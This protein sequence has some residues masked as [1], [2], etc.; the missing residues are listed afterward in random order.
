MFVI[1]SVLSGVDYGA[2]LAF[3][4][5]FAGLRWL[6]FLFV[7]MVVPF[8]LF[9]LATLVV[10][11]LG[12]PGD[13]SL[14]GLFVLFVFFGVG[15]EDD[16]DKVSWIG[17]SSF[18]Q[19]LSLLRPPINL[20]IDTT[21]YFGVAAPTPAQMDILR[22]HLIGIPPF[23]EV[24]N[25]DG[26]TALRN[27]QLFSPVGTRGDPL[28]F[29]RLHELVF[30]VCCASPHLFDYSDFTPTKFPVM[31]M[32]DI[33][34][35]ECSHQSE[36]GADSAIQTLVLQQWP[37]LKD[38]NV[39]DSW[40]TLST[41]DELIELNP[42]FT[43]LNIGICRNS[44][45]TDGVFMLERVVGR[46][47]HLTALILCSDLPVPMD[48]SWLQATSL[49]DI[50]SSKL[51][52][53]LVSKFTL[54]PRLF[55]V[56]LALPNLYE[57]AFWYCAMTE[58]ELVMNVLKKHR[59]TARED[60]TVGVRRLIIHIPMANNNWSNELVFEM[61]A[62]LPRLESCRIFGDAA[63]KSAIKEKYPNLIC[64]L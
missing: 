41:M 24:G 14:Q 26:C 25:E 55:E 59:Q 32:M 22:P 60:G 63:L 36:D 53:V 17:L 33:T 37:K 64:W 51:T 61:I 35:K 30:H 62:S 43:R 8:V 38:L 13:P 28:V 45:G 42:Q 27:R 34:G 58:S 21:K 49:V 47:P 12:G 29:S 1:F 50:R 57:M 20:Q 18:V 40:L 56:L 3:I 31:N 46:L 48:S 39:R 4:A 44:N 52:C 10:V 9:A 2:F 19:T 54:T 15:D 23:E 5:G 7:T 11:F 6:G 16:V